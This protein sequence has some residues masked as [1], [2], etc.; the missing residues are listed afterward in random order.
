MPTLRIRHCQKLHPQA[1]VKALGL[2]VAAFWLCLPVAATAKNINILSACSSEQAYQRGLCHGTLLS[3]LETA[4]FVS[5]YLPQDRR[6]LFEICMPEDLS[7][8]DVLKELKD[9]V[10]EYEP[11]TT[12]LLLNVVVGTFECQ[13]GR[14]SPEEMRYQGAPL[15]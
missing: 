1:L 2:F 15:Y 13:R 11:D 10:Y 8:E 5:Y 3:M 6:Y 4:K 7:T 9:A 12:E 14:T